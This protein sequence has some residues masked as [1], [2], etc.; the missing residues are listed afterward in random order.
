M[1]PTA[2]FDKSFLQA[3]NV[4]E[5]VL[6]DAFFLPVICPLFYVETLADLAKEP[7]SGPDQRDPKAIV[8]S[9]AYKT[10]EMNGAICAHHADMVASSLAGRHT[11][12]TGQIP[13]PQG[14]LV[15]SEGKVHVLFDV[16]PEREAFERWQDLAFDEVESRFAKR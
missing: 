13:V 4:D 11:P 14:R 6:F 1:A 9:L 3:L 12:M 10:P 7:A 2:L 16:P 8:G 5:A 15:Q